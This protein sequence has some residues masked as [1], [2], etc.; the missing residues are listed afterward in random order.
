MGVKPKETR[1]A[2]STGGEKEEAEAAPPPGKKGRLN[3]NVER[4]PSG[5]VV[6]LIHGLTGGKDRVRG[7]LL[8]LKR[9]CATGGTFE[10]G[11]IELQGDHRERVE[12]WIRASGL[13]GKGAK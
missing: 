7:F 2:Y 9:S 6:T 4:R 13:R 10:G 11:T 8:E 12:A 3:V 1:L 5:R